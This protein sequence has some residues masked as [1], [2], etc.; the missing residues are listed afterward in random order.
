MRFASEGPSRA[1]APHLF[2]GGVCPD[3]GHF[4]SLHE[5]HVINKFRPGKPTE[6]HEEVHCWAFMGTPEQPRC[7]G[8]TR[9]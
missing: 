9:S 4:R 5:P 8:C 2:K 3:C 1:I 6:R 7:C